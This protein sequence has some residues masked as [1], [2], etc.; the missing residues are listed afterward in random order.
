[1]ELLKT[2]RRELNLTT[3]IVTTRFTIGGKHITQEV[4]ASAP[5][6]IIVVHISSPDG[7]PVT[8]SFKMTREK[9]AVIKTK[10]NRHYSAFRTDHRSG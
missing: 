4:F 8:A 10:G 5:G 3:G 2:I 7:L 1:M 6:N 9:D